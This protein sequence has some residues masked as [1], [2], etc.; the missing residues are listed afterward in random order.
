MSGSRGDVRCGSDGGMSMP[1]ALFDRD[2]TTLLP[3]ALC[4][5]PWD[6]GYLHGGAV[7]GAI[8]WALEHARPDESLVLARATVEIRSMVPLGPL[9]TAQCGRQARPAD[10]GHRGHLGHR[11]RRRRPGD[12]PVGGAPPERS[13]AHAARGP[14]A[15]RSG[16]RSRRQ[17][18]PR[19]P[20]SRLQL[21][22]RRAPPAAGNDGDGGARRDLG[23]PPNPRGRGRAD[24]RTAVGHDPV[25]PRHRRRVGTQPRPA[26]RSSTPMSPCRSTAIPWGH[27]C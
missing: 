19:L 11:R 12:E 24:V 14:G 9:H 17:R 15:T 13:A 26:R 18:R 1:S 4:R 10:P 3:T 7:C 8:G 16:R 20:A 23:P 5:G 6:H 27:G 25:G 2:G 21:R 22:R